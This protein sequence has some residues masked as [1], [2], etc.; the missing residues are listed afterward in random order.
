[1]RNLH[2][3]SFFGLSLVT[4]LMLLLAG[5]QEEGDPDPPQ[6]PYDGIMQP[7]EK[8]EQPPDSNSILGLHQ[9]IFERTC[10][11]PGCHDGSFE[12]DFRTVYSTYRSLVLHPVIKNSLN[13][14]PVF[15]YRVV[16]GDY[17]SS[18]LHERVT[19]DDQTLGRMPLYKEP[20]T[21]GEIN[22]IRSWI[23]NGAPDVY[24]NAASVGPQRPKLTGL[25]SYIDTFGIWVRVD[26]FK[27]NFY[28]PI[29]SFKNQRV[30]IWFCVEDDNTPTAEL[31]LN[32]VDFG[33]TESFYIADFENG[34]SYNAQFDPQGKTITNYNGTGETKIFHWFIEVNT[35]EGYFEEGDFYQMRYHVREPGEATVP[36][37]QEDAA[38]DLKNYYTLYIL[39]S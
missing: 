17:Q 16:P 15:E 39:P 6:N 12:P 29:G 37:P 36:F 26:T 38:I 4:L 31:E 24:G 20:L 23:E 1:M 9:F 3:H 14:G 30:Q 22:A 35:A 11:D 2:P 28:D 34:R 10:A 32:R 7:V 27:T 8:E 21:A 25:I 19:T 13:G 18:W 5:C 33:K